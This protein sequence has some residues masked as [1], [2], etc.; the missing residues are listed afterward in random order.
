MMAE[1]VNEVIRVYHAQV[2]VPMGVTQTG[3][4]MYKKTMKTKIVFTIWHMNKLGYTPDT[5][6]TLIKIHGGQRKYMGEATY[7]LGH[8][9]LTRSF[10]VYLLVKTPKSQKQIPTNNANWSYGPLEVSGAATLLANKINDSKKQMHFL[11][12]WVPV[13]WFP[14][15]NDLK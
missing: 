11:F 3:E 9:N 1:N 14:K 5:P 12:P 7:A 6:D 15:S 4:V 2:M 10:Q 8:F 13:K